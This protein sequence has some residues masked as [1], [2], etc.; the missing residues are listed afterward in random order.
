MKAVTIIGSQ[1]S[2]RIYNACENQR[3]SFS[4]LVADIDLMNYY[5]VDSDG[6]KTYGTIKLKAVSQFK[7]VEALIQAMVATH[8]V[9]KREVE[10]E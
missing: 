10:S 4:D 2:C 3:I 7:Q 1:I 5:Y 6:D 8:Q 9:A